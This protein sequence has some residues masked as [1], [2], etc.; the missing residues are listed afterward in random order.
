MNPL[1]Y[2]G[3]HLGSAFASF[4]SG[5]YQTQQSQ[6]MAR[7]QMAFQERMSNT[8]VQRR[9]ADL[10][11]AGYNPLLAVGDAASSPK[12][13]MGSPGNPNPNFDPEMLIN[14]QRARA[15]I[16]N[17]NS[18]TLLNE[19]MTSQSEAQVGSIEAQSLYYQALAQK[20]LSEKAIIDATLS[21]HEA[22]G[23]TPATTTA[24]RT[25]RDIR[26]FVSE[27]SGFSKQ[28]V[29]KMAVSAGAMYAGK[30]FFGL[31]G[32]SLPVGRAARA[33]VAVSK[34]LRRMYP[35]VYKN[36][37]ENVK[38]YGGRFYGPSGKQIK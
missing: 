7:E 12:G 20:T 1:A 2:V 15:D 36:V 14:I 34:E 17:T 18:Q 32:K 33:G 31:V 37:R 5:V 11:A 19:K 38:K 27:V 26:D 35:A 28:S 22:S 29:N 30:K 25:A 23:T 6:K 8:E 13:A 16:N 3:A 21:G 10:E 24:G 4:G 9:R